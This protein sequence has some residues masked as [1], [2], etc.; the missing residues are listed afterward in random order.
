MAKVKAKAEK[1]RIKT[2]ISFFQRNAH[3]IVVA[4]FSLLLYSNSLF[5]GYNMDDELVTRNHRLTS[6]GISAIPEIFTSPYYQDEVG[7]A[8]EYRPIPLATFAIEHSLFGESA[9]MGHF[10]SWLL[11]AFM[12]MLLFRL[13]KFISGGITPVMALAAT[14]LFAAHTTHT[15]VV[16]SIKNRDE[17][18][19]FIFCLLATQMALQ[20]TR[21]R[22]WWQ[23]VVS[24][25]IFLMAM[26]CKTTFVVFA[27]LIPV[28]MVLFAEANL[29]FAAAMAILLGA[30][31]YFTLD[32]N[33][34]YYRTWFLVSLP[35][36]TTGFYT[37]VHGF[38]KQLFKR[39]LAAKQQDELVSTDPFSGLKFWYAEFNASALYAALP[40]VILL[41]VFAA[42]GSNGFLWIGLAAVALLATVYLFFTNREYWSIGL[43]N[44]L[45][46]GFLYFSG[47]GALGG[48]F[49]RYQFFGLLYIL[50]FLFWWAKPALRLPALI[51]ALALAVSYFPV[52]LTGF[53]LVFCLFM[54]TRLSVGRKILGAIVSFQVLVILVWLIFGL[55]KLSFQMFDVADY[56]QFSF[57]L[58]MLN[59]KGSW[60][61][62]AQHA[63]KLTTI[64]AGVLLSVLVWSIG[65]HIQQQ[66]KATVYSNKHIPNIAESLV[67]TKTDRPLNFVEFPIEPQTSTDIKAGT[68]LTVLGFYLSKTIIPYP[69]SFYYGYAFIK[70]ESI[71]QAYPVA[72]AVIYSIL[73]LVVLFFLRKNKPV[74]FALILF[75][76]P[77]LLYCGYLRSVPGIVADRYLLIPTMGWSI[78]LTI[79]LFRIFKAEKLEPVGLSFRI[80]QFPKGLTYSLLAILLL[81]SGFTFSRNFYWDNDLALMRHDISYV[82]SSAQAHNLLA[83]H[84]LK[85]QQAEPDLNKKTALAKEGLRHFKAALQIYPP[86]FNAAYDV[87]RVYLLL[88]LPDSALI[89][90]KH[91]MTIEPKFG[92]LYIGIADIYMYKGLYQ[93]AVPYLEKYIEKRPASYV[94]YD[95][96]SYSYYRLSQFE[97]SIAVNRNAAARFPEY[98]NPIVNIGQTYLAQGNTDSAMYYC[99][100]ALTKD[101]KNS[102]ALQL[103]Q[104]INK[105]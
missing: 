32:V 26:L 80:S 105:K 89:A 38:G 75:I 51:A 14:L 42:L 90:F 46:C 23:I 2:E 27:L 1:Q 92:D 74:S 9:G 103:L 94:G 17:I 64:A 21:K 57:A 102:T 50:L 20:G 18:L 33:P 67:T 13:L 98:L 5:N 93:E 35:V 69:L 61:F 87:G 41:I 4:V 11:Y 36:A 60:K 56:L 95:K 39:V 100:I 7:Y 70:P 82:D 55:R 8:Y 59:W 81:Y 76:L 54:A 101:P 25:A 66:T 28:A 84:L 29:L 58:L 68:A 3:Y 24:A 22:Q 73:M 19:G 83:L 16:C 65:D 43:F 86:F 12:C 85:Q 34:P 6:K 31:S 40:T 52:K 47:T 30:V 99:Q 37:M 49:Q 78:L 72:V 77:V 63:A 71:K 79:V 104:Q 91:A 88:N 44:A 48:S 97:K 10:I 96:L 45:L 62:I 15:E 53:P